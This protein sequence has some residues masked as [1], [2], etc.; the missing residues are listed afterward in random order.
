[1]L[2]NHGVVEYAGANEGAAYEHAE[3]SSLEGV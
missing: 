3:Y 2:S 1:M